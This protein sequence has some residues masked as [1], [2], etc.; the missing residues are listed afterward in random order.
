MFPST[1]QLRKDDYNKFVLLLRK[2]VYPMHMWIVISDLKKLTYHLRHALIV[3]VIK[4]K[5]Q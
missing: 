3:K 5:L 1:Y 4:N 2:G